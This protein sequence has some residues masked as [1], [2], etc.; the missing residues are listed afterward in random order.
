[1]NSQTTALA[2]QRADHRAEDLQHVFDRLF[3]RD[4]NTCLRGGGVEPLYL[5]ADAASAPHRVIFREDYFASALHEVAHWCIAG[6][7]RRQ[8]LDYGYWY[9]PDGRDTRQQRH[10]EQAEAGPQALECL[11]SAACGCP[12]RPSA[13]NLAAPERD[14]NRFAAAIFVR[15]REYCERGLPARAERFRRALCQLYGTDPGLDAAN[16]PV[17][18]WR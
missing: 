2:S 1:M 14:S 18:R 12:F 8:L 13:D 5:P 17:E 4:Y 15:L 3:L 7:R 16:F 6:P 11:F 9:L 10:F